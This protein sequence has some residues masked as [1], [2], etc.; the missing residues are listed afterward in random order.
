MRGTQGSKARDKKKTAATLTG[1]LRLEQ[2]VAGSVERVC[3]HFA[4]L[5]SEMLHLAC[6]NFILY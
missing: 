1:Q 4:Q 6:S 3:A 5:L 2:R